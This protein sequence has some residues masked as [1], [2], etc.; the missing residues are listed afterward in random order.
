MESEL[1]L[2]LAIDI[3]DALDAAHQAGI[4]HR[5]INHGFIESAREDFARFT[6]SSTA[7]FP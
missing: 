5:D 7:R 6:S 1:L 4:I 3:T 2:T